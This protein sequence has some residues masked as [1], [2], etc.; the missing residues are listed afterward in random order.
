MPMT[1]WIYFTSDFSRFGFTSPQIYFPGLDLLYHLEKKE[2]LLTLLSG[3][4]HTEVI[5]M[6]CKSH[7][8][9]GNEFS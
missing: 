3:E 8:L 6:V 4:Y 9:Q 1:L 5:L 2:E 7:H